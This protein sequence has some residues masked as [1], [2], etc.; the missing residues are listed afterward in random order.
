MTFLIATSAAAVVTGV[1]VEWAQRRCELWAQLRDKDAGATALAVSGYVGI[2]LSN[3]P[4]NALAEYRGI[5]LSGLVGMGILTAL[6][7][8]AYMAVRI[9]WA[10]RPAALRPGA[11][12]VH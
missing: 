8:A 1:F 5:L 2:S 4:G 3:Q 9:G 12:P 6:G 11:E 7:F 10:P